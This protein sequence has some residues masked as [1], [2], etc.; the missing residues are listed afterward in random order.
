MF[1]RDPLT[2]SDDV[3]KPFANS[4]KVVIDDATKDAERWNKAELSALNRAA[5]RLS[6]NGGGRGGVLPELVKSLLA[7]VPGVS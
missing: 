2:Y 6:E 4:M 3:L 5:G 7:L 1:D